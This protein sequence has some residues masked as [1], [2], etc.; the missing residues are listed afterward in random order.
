VGGV[1][2]TVRDDIDCNGDGLNDL[3]CTDKNGGVGISLSGTDCS[4]GWP[5]G[6]RSLC[7]SYFE[8]MCIRRL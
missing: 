6:K 8:R 4:D 5:N 1:P 7:P 2:A 3:I